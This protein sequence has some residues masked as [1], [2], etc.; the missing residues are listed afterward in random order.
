VKVHKEL[1]FSIVDISSKNYIL[2]VIGL[3][4]REYFYFPFGLKNVK[5]NTVRP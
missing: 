4:E 2:Y 3:K 5:Q 1:Y